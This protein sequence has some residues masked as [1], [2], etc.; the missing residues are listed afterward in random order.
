MNTVFDYTA[1]ETSFRALRHG[2]REKRND[3]ERIFRG[4]HRVVVVVVAV[5]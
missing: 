2:K 3:N 4:G 1:R 5:G